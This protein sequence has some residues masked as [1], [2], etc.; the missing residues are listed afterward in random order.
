MVKFTL[1]N[2]YNIIIKWNINLFPEKQD[3]LNIIL[4]K[5][6]AWNFYCIILKLKLCNKN[7]NI[8]FR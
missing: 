7:S 6:S 4:D 2:I 1:D 5:K 8:W 3:K